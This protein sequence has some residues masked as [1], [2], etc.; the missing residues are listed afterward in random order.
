MESIQL[1]HT[2]IKGDQ[3]SQR[4]TSIPVHVLS[5]KARAVNTGK[6]IDNFTFVGLQGN[7]KIYI[8][9][10]TRIPVQ[11]KGDYKGL[12]EVKLKLRQMVH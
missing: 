4:D 5:L 3:L 10:E 9:P 1:D 2:E 11:L 8:D 12:G 6:A 7:I